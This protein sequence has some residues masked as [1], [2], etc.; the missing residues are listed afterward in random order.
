MDPNQFSSHTREI[1]SS[2]VTTS[3]ACAHELGQ[4][5]ELLARERE[6]VAVQERPARA[7]LDPQ[8]PD[9]DVRRRGAAGFTRRRTARIRAI[10]SAPLNGLTT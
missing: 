1:R 2:R 8:R 7:Q 3:P 4:Q 9:H 5:V 6:L 10:T